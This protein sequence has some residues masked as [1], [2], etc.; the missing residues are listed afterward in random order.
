MAILSG[1]EDKTLRLWEAATGQYLR[2]FEGHTKAVTSIALSRDGEHV[3]S[4]SD[5]G[6]LRL[7]RPAEGEC[8]SILH[9]DGP[10][11][12]VKLSPD[13]TLALAAQGSS[14]QIWHLDWE[15]WACLAA[16]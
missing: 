14:I 8:V 5:D 12:S 11:L 7:W 15:L 2:T 13:A 10:V 6:T 1:S 3:L 16:R 4:G 9:A